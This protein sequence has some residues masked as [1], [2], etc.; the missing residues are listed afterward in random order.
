VKKILTTKKRIVI[1]AGAGVAV[2]VTGGTAFA[3]YTSSGSGTGSATAG[4]AGT[5]DWGIQQTGSSGATALFPVAAG[6]TLDATNS[7]TLTFT[8]TN[9]GKGDEAFASSDVA[10]SVPTYTGNTDAETATTSSGVTTFAD[11]PG[12][13]AGWFTATVPSGQAAF[14][15]SIG[16]GDTAAVTVTVSMT[17]EPTNQ[18][19]CAGKTPAVNLA[20]NKS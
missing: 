7:E 1:A 6:T 17:D 15:T 12:C 3:F 19:A 5:S 4:S 10:A 2:L 13:A 20:I 9:N 14:G 11:I 16:P 18:D 8:V